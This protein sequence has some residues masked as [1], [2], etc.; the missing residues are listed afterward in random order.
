MDPSEREEGCLVKVIYGVGINLWHFLL[1]ST[2]RRPIFF[3]EYDKTRIPEKLLVM[4]K[5]YWPSVHP[6]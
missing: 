2:V 1:G 3:S 6:V 4:T 5:L